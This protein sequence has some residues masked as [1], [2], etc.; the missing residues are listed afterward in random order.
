MRSLYLILSV[1]LFVSHAYAQPPS[2]YRLWYRQ[3]AANWNEALPVGNGRIGAMVFGGTGE[4]HLQLNEETVWAGE[5]GNNIPSTGFREALPEIRR[6]IFEEKHEEAHALAMEK[7][8]RNPQ[9]TNYGMP[10]QTL[11][12]LLIRF[13]GH[14]QVTDYAR[15]LDIATAVATTTYKID[16][17]IY[18]REVWTSFVDQVLVVRLTASKPGQISCTLRMKTPQ[19]DHRVFTKEKTIVL[20]GVSGS[21]D[22]K[23][24][25]V[26]F[27]AHV[28]PLLLGGSLTATDSTL[29]I[30][31]ADVA[32]LYISMA[33]NFKRYNDIS[34]NA[35]ERASQY[36]SKAVVLDYDKA[37][38]AHSKFYQQFFNRVSLDLGS[39]A[40]SQEPTDV[41]L[42]AFQKRNDPQLVSLYFQFGRYLL[43]SSSQP[44]TQPANLQGIWNDHV[45]PPWGSKYT[46]NINTEMNYWPAEVTNLSELHAPLFNMLDDLSVT[47]RAS[48]ASLY[49]ARG[50][51][52]HHNTDL[53]RITGPVDGA[54]YGLWPMGGAWLSQHLWQHYLYTGDVAFLKKAY[55]VLKS[56][57]IFFVDV[58]QEEPSHRWLVVSPSMS[59]ENAHHG[60]VSI[61]AGTTMDNQLVHDVFSN[62]IEASR[63]LNVE[64]DF[65]DTI[66][67]KIDRLPPMQIGHFGQLQEWLKDWDRPDDKHRHVS[68]LYGLYPSNQ[69]SPY[70]YPELFAAARTTLE[71]RGDRSTGWSMGW[72]VNWWARLLDGER[73]Y[74]LIHE[75]LT[76]TDGK[77]GGTYANLFDAHPPFQI[78]GN[79]GCTSGIAEM[80]MQSH[81]G[82][83]HLLPAL[84]AVWPDG[85]V[86]GLKTRGGFTI[87][88]TWKQGKISALEIKSSLGGNLRLRSFTALV[89]KQ[90]KIATGENPNALF[91]TAS[92]KKPLISPEAKITPPEIKPMFEYDLLTEK[93][94]T[95]T[96]KF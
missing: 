29:G 88:M 61:T 6:L 39:S 3:P 7:L 68:H 46:I 30:V 71:H 8:P 79:F 70:R 66:R 64:K 9:G 78:D 94:K 38:A 42:K 69:V 26:A 53:W 2:A 14:D 16:N 80:L 21:R 18:R 76:Y 83:V 1:L 15:D 35:G 57:A 73:A 27:E 59:P 43:I 20:A 28:K 50:W 32:T 31:N 96:F 11:G 23:K 55:P 25:R 24:G 5:P 91:K 85:S 49:G 95:Y 4:E 40:N 65:A 54:F 41:R 72:K 87:S 63:V 47:G 13:P 93:G 92:I 48:A 75:Q 84:P 62:V 58:L 17:V 81:D 52:A 10:Y 45:S 36:L 56:A 34:G 51:A 12:D 86:K 67:T 90:M 82:A 37:K 77:E 74:K 19:S 44:D 33:T 22:D 89:N 60:E